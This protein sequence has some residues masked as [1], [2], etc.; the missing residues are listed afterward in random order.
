MIYYSLPSKEFFLKKIFLFLSILFLLE[1]VSLT[2]KCFNFKDG[3]GIKVCLP[4]TGIS[5]EKKA[6][7]ACKKVKG[8]ECGNVTGYSGS[9]KGRCVDES[10]TEKKELKAD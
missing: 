1:T 8:S 10:G 4:G 9:C 5:A 2:A 3:D 7:A 6:K